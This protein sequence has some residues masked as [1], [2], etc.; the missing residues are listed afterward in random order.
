MKTIINGCP[1]HLP[2][3][4]DEELEGLLAA[5]SARREQIHAESVALREEQR[6]R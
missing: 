6:R 5:Q 3:L 4:S 1:L 2:S